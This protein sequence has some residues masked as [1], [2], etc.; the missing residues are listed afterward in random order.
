MK[1]I[2]EA[3]AT[4]IGIQHAKE[5]LASEPHLT[6]VD[7]VVYK[8][9]IGDRSDPI[10]MV[11]VERD[12]EPVHHGRPSHV[13]MFTGGGMLCTKHGGLCQIE[14]DSRLGRA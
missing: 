10:S 13:Y 6:G 11:T 9:E 3:E 8:G 7:V 14:D 4:Q 1:K 2:E 12:K 5:I